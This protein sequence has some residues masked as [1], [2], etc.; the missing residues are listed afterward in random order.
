M[1]PASLVPKER[2]DCQHARMTACHHPTQ[3]KPVRANGCKGAG[4]A[5][6]SAKTDWPRRVGLS[7]SAEFGQLS[8]RVEADVQPSYRKWPLRVIFLS[9]MIVTSGRRGCGDLMGRSSCLFPAGEWRGFGGAGLL[10]FATPRGAGGRPPPPQE[11]APGK[12]GEN[13]P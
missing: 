4:R 2:L 3:P 12:A 13:P 6:P 7:G 1:A 9:L 10:C 11:D 8:Q 5:V